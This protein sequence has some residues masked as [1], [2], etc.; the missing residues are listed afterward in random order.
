M[1]KPL[2]TGLA[3]VFAFTA[4]SAQ[5]RTSYI[6]PYNFAPTDAYV[7]AQAATSENVFTPEG[8]LKLDAFQVIDSAGVVTT[9]K[10]VAFKEVTLFE[11]ALPHEGTFRLTT[12]NREMRTMQ[13]M[14]IDGKWRP[15]RGPGGPARPGGEGKPAEGAP[16]TPVQPAAQAQAIP[17]DAKTVTVKSMMR[18]DSYISYKKP[19]DT[20]PPAEGKGLEIVPVT[21]PNRLFSGNAFDFIVTFDGQPLSGVTY[22]VSRGGDQYADSSYALSADSAAGGKGEVVFQTPGIY[23]IEISRKW[24]D[25][26]L[27]DP[28]SWSYSLTVEVAP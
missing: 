27:T 13:M 21:H 28:R 5:A 2:L 16:Q 19:S 3:V 18:A 1:F 20:L 11:S 22:K 9:A 26:D 15:V 10:G 7:T 6:L 8:A 12:G 14:Q 23:V 25:G 4:A 24:L 17:A